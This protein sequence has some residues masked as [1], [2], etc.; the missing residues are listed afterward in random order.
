MN[1][2]NLSPMPSLSC[3]TKTMNLPNRSMVGTV[4]TSSGLAYSWALSAHCLGKYTL[5]ILF[6]RAV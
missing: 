4:G 3:L 2:F 5:K 1:K 6:Y